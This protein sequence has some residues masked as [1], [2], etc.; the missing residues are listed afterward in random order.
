MSETP[1]RRVTDRQSG[2]PTL[3]GSGSKFV[4]NL[5]CGGDLVVGGHIHG[6]GSV[7]GALTVSEGSRWQGDIHATNAVVAG[8]IEGTL[9]IV[10]KL[11][12]RKTAR[13]R[14]SVRARSIAVARG[15][16]IEGDMAVTSG[17]AV[18]HYDE[19]RNR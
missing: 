5:E 16:V 3:V 17:A 7:R 2:S 15:A 1:R 18:V 8:E 9:A 19:K 10:E 12:I 13:I 6:D 11:E 4:G 14:G